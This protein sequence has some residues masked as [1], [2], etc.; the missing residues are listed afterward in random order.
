[1]LVKE[2]L[3]RMDRGY[4]EKEDGAVK[5]DIRV[6]GFGYLLLA[7]VKKIHIERDGTVSI[8]AEGENEYR[9][10][11]DSKTLKELNAERFA[12]KEEGG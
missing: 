2:V 12:K 8:W 7:E 11:I 6:T 5:I 4:A 3:E 9:S 1:M 10:A